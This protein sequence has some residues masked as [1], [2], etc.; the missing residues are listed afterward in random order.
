MDRRTG[1]EGVDSGLDAWWALARRS[2]PVP[3]AA[4]MARVL[5]EATAHQPAAVGGV[6]RPSL[7]VYRPAWTGLSGWRMWGERWSQAWRGGA[8]AGGLA[9]VLAAAWWMDARALADQR[10]ALSVLEAEL[11]E[12]EVV[13]IWDAAS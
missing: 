2:P 5:D 12:A 1:Q 7:G 13:A 10:E 8:L 4:L 11:W 6:E 9:S 3:S